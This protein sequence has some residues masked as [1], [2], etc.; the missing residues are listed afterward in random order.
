MDITNKKVIVVGGSSGMGLGVAQAALAKG[1]EVIIVGRSQARLAKASE[2][3]VG[4]GRVRTFAA[5]VTS[6]YEVRNLFETIGHFDHL[7]VTA[8]ADLAYPT[9][10][11]LDL[12]AA[13]RSIDSKLIAAL[14]LAK[15]AAANIDE[16]GS[17]TFTAGIAAERPMPTGFLVA[18]ING[19]LF[20]LTYGL[21]VALAPVRVN[22]LS[23]GWIDTPIWVTSALAAN[24]VAM[25]EQMIPRLPA[26]RIGQSSDI[27]HA[28]VFLME[29]EFTT[30]IILPV[31]G[32][33]R[34]V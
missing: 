20:S 9:I 31:D 11:E 1:A 34:L 7:V 8:A 10:R 6:E 18:A 24:R 13:R 15:Y 30:G 33:H 22:V 14:L 4:T 23:P 12:D 21:A 19:S 25:F 27:G 2:E 17:I 16:R 32:G 28:A 3:L 26:R 5:N 29:N